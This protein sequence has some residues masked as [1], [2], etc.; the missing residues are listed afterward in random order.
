MSSILQHHGSTTSKQKHGYVELLFYLVHKTQDWERYNG[1]NAYKP[2]PN[3]TTFC[4]D[5]EPI[6]IRPGKFVPQLYRVWRKP[7]GMFGHFVVFRYL[8]EEHVPD[9]SVPIATFK[10]PRGAEALTPGEMLK[11]WFE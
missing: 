4:A 1:P 9:L 3:S 8:G 7:V 11:Y 5:S 10:L 6:E 2:N